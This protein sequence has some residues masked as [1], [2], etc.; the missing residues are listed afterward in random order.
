[1]RELLIP[2]ALTAAA[3]ALAETVALVL[4]WSPPLWL[5]AAL[6]AEAGA[7]AFLVAGRR[8]ALRLQARRRARARTRRGP[9]REST[10]PVGP[11]A[12][13]AMAAAAPDRGG[14]SSVRR[15]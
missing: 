5:L 9:P 1:M 6:V 10:A 12:E 14:P 7:A 8:R 11:A 2:A 3:V 4:G 13:T 15:L